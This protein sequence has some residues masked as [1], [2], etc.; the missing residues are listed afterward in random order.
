MLN[1]AL[2]ARVLAAR[3]LCRQRGITQDQVA[4][5]VGASQSQ[6]SRIL[7]G[8]GL[9]QSRL[10]EEVCLYVEGFGVGVTVELVRSNEDLMGALSSIWDGS[11][12]HARALATVIR[13]LAALNATATRA[14]AAFED[15]R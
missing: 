6:V 8:R 4:E 11:A 7:S 3:E 14:N 1:P 5:A 9:R 10:L 12:T 13:S 2:E 15:A